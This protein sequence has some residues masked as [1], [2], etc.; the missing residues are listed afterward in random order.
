MPDKAELI[1]IR[2]YPT[3]LALADK[4]VSYRKFR[5]RGRLFG[6][7]MKKEVREIKLEQTTK[8]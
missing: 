7:L 6:Y 5:G 8:G 2:L 1:T 4:L 3:E